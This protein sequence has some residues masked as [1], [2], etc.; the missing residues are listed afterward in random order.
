MQAA[1]ASLAR[2]NSLII[3]PEGTRT[4]PGRP[5]RMQRGAANVALRLAQPIRPVLISVAPD[6]LTKHRPWYQIPLEGPFTMS[7][8]AMPELEVVDAYEQLP[9]AVAARK[10]T[11]SL[12]DYFTEELKTH[13]IAGT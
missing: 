5:I 10:L 2:G 11:Q 9:R 4:V 6:T 8:A 12:E 7:L 1:R 3:F 13:G